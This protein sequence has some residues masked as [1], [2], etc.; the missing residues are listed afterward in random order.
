[1]SNPLDDIELNMILSAVLNCEA[2]LAAAK[3]TYDE[4]DKLT[5][6]LRER[7][8][9]NAFHEGH[10]M[11]LVNN[12]VDKDGNEKNV[13]WKAAGVKMWEVKVKALK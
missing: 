8:F 2:K 3:A 12:F 6:L 7:G 10:E 4:L 1:M 9:T 5:K 13:A 11:T